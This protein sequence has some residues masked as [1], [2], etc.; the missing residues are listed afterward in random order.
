MSATTDIVSATILALGHEY[1]LSEQDKRLVRSALD[2]AMRWRPMA[3]ARKD[4]TPVLL[5]TKADL[6]LDRD[7]L[8]RWRG[9]QFVGRYIVCEDGWSG[10]NIAAPVGSSG[11][12]PDDWF[13]GWMPS[14]ARARGDQRAVV[15]ASGRPRHCKDRSC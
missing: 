10:W 8:E 2:C 4:R 5:L 6:R 13:V 14:L 9:I 12:C 3:T 1:F 11:G 15:R 7:D